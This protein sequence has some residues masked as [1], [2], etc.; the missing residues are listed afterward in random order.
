MRDKILLAIW[1]IFMVTIIFIGV[2]GI[3]K[4]LS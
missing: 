1:L 3:V 2:S 4:V